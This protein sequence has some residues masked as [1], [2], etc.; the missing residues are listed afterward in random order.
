[1]SD[2]STPETDPE[3]P[4]EPV[5]EATLP[6]EE[7][8][9]LDRLTEELQAANDRCVRAQ[10]DLE[11]FRKRARREMDDERRYA[12]LPLLR[13]LLAVVDNLGRAVQAAEQQQDSGL[14]EGVQ[15][16]LSQFESILNQ[17]HCQE[18]QAAGVPFDPNLH[19]AISQLPSDEYEA[20]IVAQVAIAGYQLHD[21]VIRPAQVIV[22]TGPAAPSTDDAAEA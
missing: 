17:H 21:R 4:T 6:M 14:V 18:I 22:S 5:E 20:G 13:D 9:E 16:V 1:M 3:T 15:M 8:S 19:E 10:A 7:P 11:N 12:P 2:T